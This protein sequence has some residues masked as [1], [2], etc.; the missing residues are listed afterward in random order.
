MLN[1][2]ERAE[3]SNLE[4]LGALRDGKTDGAVEAFGIGPI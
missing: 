1:E 4:G 3:L 2:T